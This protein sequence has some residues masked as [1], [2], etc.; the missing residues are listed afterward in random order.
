MTR[1]KKSKSESRLQFETLNHRVMLDG[2]GF[3]DPVFYG[4]T[5]YLSEADTPAGF[6]PVADCD[7]CVVGLET[8]EDNSLD[9]GIQINT[10]QIIGPGFSTGLRRTSPTQLMVTTG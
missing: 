8:F 2:A 9:F 6:V 10:G 1:K 3:V 4:P 5:P 7:E